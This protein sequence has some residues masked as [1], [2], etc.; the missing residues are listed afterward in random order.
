VLPAVALLAV[1][2]AVLAIGAEWGVRG[3]ARFSIAAG[4]PPFAL[5][6][7]LFGIDLEGTAAAVIAAGRDQPALAAG[8]AFGTIL[9]LFSAAFGAALLVTRRSVP[10][11]TTAM[12]VAPATAAAACAIAVSDRLVTRIEGVLLIL[13]YVGYVA[14]VVAEGRAV[15]RRTEA[16]QRE[17]AGVSGGRARAAAVTVIGL[18]A[19]FAGAWLLVEG[20]VRVL[21][22]TGLAAGFVGAAVIGVLASLDEVLLEI[23]P[24]R[25]GTPELATG[26][27]FGTAAA[28]ASFVP[29]LAAVVRP[30]EIDGAAAAAFLGAV[31]LYA[32]VSAVFLWRE[33]AGRILGVVVLGGYAAWLATAS[34]I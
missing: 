1:G 27:L 15:R 6:A 21:E 11:P 23:L 34:S 26:N 29:G 22:L 5:G 4:I 8:E 33:R 32:M 20:G 16:L 13:V 2:A 19:V 24:V 25:R 9:F 18:G 7:L 30:L 28:F 10:A 14:G 31:T 12:I 3:A 17:A